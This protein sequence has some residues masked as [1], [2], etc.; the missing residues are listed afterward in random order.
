MTSASASP[1]HMVRMPSKTQAAI[2]QPKLGTASAT[3][4]GFLKTPEPMTLPTTTAVVIHGPRAR[5]RC[6]AEGEVLESE[7]DFMKSS[8]GVAE[9]GGTSR[10]KRARNR[11]QKLLAPRAT[12]RALFF[13]VDSW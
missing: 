2:A 7:K 8:G 1:P 3:S 11:K 13:R 4:A 6:A 5:T 12:F 10:A 9:P